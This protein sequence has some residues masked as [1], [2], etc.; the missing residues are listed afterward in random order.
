M[1]TIISDLQV[2]NT[3]TVNGVAIGVITQTEVDFGATPVSEASFNVTHSGATA[4]TKV[5][6]FVSYEAPTG[7]DLDEIEMDDLIIRGAGTGTNQLTF[8]IKSDDGSYLHDKFKIN[9]I[10]Y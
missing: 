1:P 6:A 7:K 5:I 9:Y 3:L 8:Y 10:I 2:E 4:S